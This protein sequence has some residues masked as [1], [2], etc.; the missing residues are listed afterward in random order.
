MKAALF[1]L[2][3]PVLFA[4]GASQ[5][6]PYAA[7]GGVGLPIEQ[8][9][10]QCN[11]SRCVDVRTGVYTQS[12]CNNRGCFPLGGARGQLNEYGQ[13]QRYDRRGYGQSREY[14]QRRSYDGE[15]PRYR[16]QYRDDD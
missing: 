14:G 15:R 6:M 7:H 2:G 12:T 5:A 11:R 3:L 13:D 9:Q 8:V 10:M 4:S 16:R 1:A